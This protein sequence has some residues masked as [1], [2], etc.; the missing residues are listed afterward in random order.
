MLPSDAPFVLLDDARDAGRG[1]RLY[2]DPV[3]VVAGHRVAEVWPALEAIRAGQREGLHAAGYLA[4]EAAAAFEP[5]L[6]RVPA[7]DT[8]L[9]WFGLFAGWQDLAADDV[10]ALLP[11]PA[12]A[13]LGPPEPAIDHATYAARFAA[14][15]ELIAAGDIY[16]ANL[17]YPAAVP[18][19]GDP[20]APS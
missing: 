17:T 3:R 16:Q 1:A 8:P 19:Q 4:Y 18:V 11:D 7:A 14:V 9:L 20:R 6:A 5:T 10:P 15:R 13:W 12:G 2:R